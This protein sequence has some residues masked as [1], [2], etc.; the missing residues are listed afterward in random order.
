[1]QNKKK[2]KESRKKVTQI[3]PTISISK[4][5]S[6][7]ST[8]NL[9]TTSAYNNNNINNVDVNPNNNVNAAAMIAMMNL[10]NMNKV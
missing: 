3:I 7:T 9:P 4:S 10:L 6:N 8:Q 2:I 1:M 5:G